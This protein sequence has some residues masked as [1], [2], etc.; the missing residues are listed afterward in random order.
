MKFQK[1]FSRAGGMRYACR[2]I[3][4]Q[5]I[6]A[7]LIIV[8][9]AAASNAK[10]QTP[11]V[12]VLEADG[13]TTVRG[14]IGN[15]NSFQR[16][17]QIKLDGTGSVRVRFLPSDLVTNSG[18]LIDRRHITVT[19]DAQLTREPRDFVLKVSGVVAAGDYS[20]TILIT[21]DSAD[22]S[23]V[24]LPVKLE[25]RPTVNITL[26]QETPS[27]SIK[28]VTSCDWLTCFALGSSACAASKTHSVFVRAQGG[29]LPPM[30][31]LTLIA[32]GPNGISLK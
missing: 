12:V 18:Q 20:G 1:I 19:G 9:L 26:A 23:A 10:A 28:L 24:R 25:A 15:E 16:T 30:K 32:V 5:S 29:E 21:L 11:K 14:Q 4:R 27:F 6:C 22:Q 17:F 3:V 2:A 31:K 13:Q 8:A 7:V